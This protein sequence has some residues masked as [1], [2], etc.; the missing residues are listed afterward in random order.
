MKAVSQPALL[1]GGG[2]AVN[3]SVSHE[4]GEKLRQRR[5]TRLD[6]RLYAEPDAI[7]SVTIGTRDRRAFFSSAAVAAATIEVLQAHSAKTGVKV[8]GFCVMPDHVHLVVSPSAECD[9]ITFV[10]QFKNLAQRAVWQTGVDGRIWQTSFWDHF[11]RKDED[12]ERVVN[13]V[14]DNPVR[15][16]LVTERKDHQFAGSLVFDL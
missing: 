16:G 15:K 6:A 8:Y 12:V 14:L 3:P 13:Y 7:C 4:M 11:L 5:H 1:H 10:G 2:R 9:I